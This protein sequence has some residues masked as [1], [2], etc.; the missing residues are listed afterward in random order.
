MTTAPFRDAVVGPPETS[1][2]G[3]KYGR[4][5]PT[6]S[7]AYWLGTGALVRLIPLGIFLLVVLARVLNVALTPSGP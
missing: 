3:A 5:L 2:P 4:N 1:S 7:S 6:E